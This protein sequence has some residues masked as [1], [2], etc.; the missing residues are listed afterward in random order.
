[1]AGANLGELKVDGRSDH[2]EGLSLRLYNP[3]TH[4]W[5]ISWANASDGLLGEAMTGEFRDGRGE[6]FGEESLNGRAILVRF[7]FSDIT[8]EKFRFEQ[9]FSDDWGKTWE[10]NW[11]ATFTR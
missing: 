11:K 2:I 8:S 1:M 6:F 3:Q 4:Q 7:V 9:A 10:V 5:N